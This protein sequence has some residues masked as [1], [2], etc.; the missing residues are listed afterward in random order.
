MKQQVNNEPIAT[1][2]HFPIMVLI[3][4]VTDEYVVFKMG[5]AWKDAAWY[6]ENQKVQMRKL[7]HSVRRGYYFVTDGG[8]K[9][10][11]EALRT[12]WGGSF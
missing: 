6:V 9:Y 7:Y 4:E 10:L 1:I 2:Q 5:S 11:D 8:R 12:N 3:Y